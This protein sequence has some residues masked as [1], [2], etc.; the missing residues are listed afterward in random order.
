MTFVN[1]Q[2][3]P[4]V[5]LTVKGVSTGSD[6]V[7]AAPQA[8]ARAFRL[9]GLADG[10]L[11][12]QLRN[13]DG[14]DNASDLGSRHFFRDSHRLD[15]AVRKAGGMRNPT[16]R[17]SQYQL[18]HPFSFG[19]GD[20]P[21]ERPLTAPT[22]AAVNRV[23]KYTRDKLAY[24]KRAMEAIDLGDYTTHN[25]DT[26]HPRFLEYVHERVE[27]VDGPT[28]EAMRAAQGVLLDM[29]GRLGNGVEARPLSDAAPDTLLGIIKKGSVGEYRSLGAED[30]RDPRLVATMSS[31]L[32]R[33]GRAG[34][35]VAAGRP[36]PGWVD[37]TMQPSLS[38]GKREP[39][40]AKVKD[41]K[42][43]APV[44]RFIFNVSPIN[45]ALGSFLHYDLSHFLQER[46][47]TH[48]PGFGPGRGRA[49]KFLGLLDDVTGS[50]YTTRDGARLIM[51]DIYKWDANMVEALLGY[52]FDVI[53]D[54]VSKLGLDTRALATRALMV[55]VARRQLMEKL[56]E[57]PAGYFVRLFGCMPSGSFY[58]SLVNT[59]GNNLLV[60]GHLI[61]RAV[62]E[63]GYTH[64]GAAG[65]VSGLVERFLRSYG[66]NQLFS[67]ELFLALGLA[68]DA[69]KHAEFLA[70]FGMTLK[71][72][73]TE[74]STRLCRARFCS[75]G[76]VRT[77]YGLLVMRSHDSL[78]AKL[79]GRPEHDPLI[80]KLYVRAMMVDHMGTDPIVFELL[81][82]IDRS[83]NVNLSGSALTP[84]VRRVLEDTA[85]SMF[86]DRGDESLMAV[87]RAVSGTTVDR[88]A[89]LSL[90]TPRVV[91]DSTPR[92]GSSVTTGLDL[93]VGS[94]TPAAQ[95]AYEM[96]PG[97]WCRYLE[98]T[99]QEEVMY[100]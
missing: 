17:I 76:A 19:G 90:H 51:S 95:W 25:P 5:E 56:V 36:Y 78:Y 54:G 12:N 82:D 22:I 88:R 38:F 55:K 28:D 13:Y 40:A 64:A 73:E 84:A 34:A 50:G 81:S 14:V 59:T 9:K 4:P 8:R 11:L 37:T 98:E 68:Y 7:I 87:L 2:N 58:T 44:P 75:R 30:R 23:A 47:P 85:R 16:M 65:A 1:D 80:D 26:L 71:V 21:K 10:D 29:W 20:A 45:Y 18:P 39:K 33:Y 94:L 27:K 46:D 57:H 49:A 91:G 61:D 83:L 43:V 99:G 48:G 32:M 52:A 24:K 15:A 41:G 60:L 97:E 66:D 6:P 67:E 79:A 31:S 53:E 74:V 69:D 63:R 72:E 93:F 100:D 89:L 70:R 92:L 86:G 42:R 96:T 3:Q 77:P 35:A 62:R